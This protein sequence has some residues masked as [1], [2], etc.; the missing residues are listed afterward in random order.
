MNNHHMTASQ[1]SNQDQGVGIRVGAAAIT[2]RYVA[3]Y[4]F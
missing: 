4:T 1:S 3:V 2:V